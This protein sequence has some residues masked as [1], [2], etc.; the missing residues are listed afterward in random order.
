MRTTV[1]TASTD[2]MEEKRKIKLFVIWGPHG[3]KAFNYRAQLISKMQHLTDEFELKTE[4]AF[5]RKRRR[6]RRN[7]MDRK[8]KGG[9]I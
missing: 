4:I 9:L 7:R 6:R 1:H 3:Q 2:W 8:Q 5:G